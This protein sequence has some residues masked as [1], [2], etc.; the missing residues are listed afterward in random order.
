MS[1][2]MNDLAFRGIKAPIPELFPIF[3]AFNV[4]HKV[5]QDNP[6]SVFMAILLILSNFGSFSKESYLH[7]EVFKSYR[8]LF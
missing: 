4:K 1:D 8:I 3:E 6:I 5:S 2:H 7:I